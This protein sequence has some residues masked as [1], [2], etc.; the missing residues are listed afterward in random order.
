MQRAVIKNHKNLDLVINYKLAELNSKGL[1]FVQHGLTG[2]KEQS[3]IKA[4]ADS[5]IDNN[6]SVVVFDATNSV[7]ESGISEE[8]VSFASHY[9]DLE[10][11]IAWSGLQN[12]FTTPFILVGHSLGG[13][14]VIYYT[15]NHLKDIR[16]LVPVSSAFDRNQ[17]YELRK[18]EIGGNFN[19][20]KKNGFYEKTSAVTGRTVK[21][22]FSFLADSREVNTY[23]LKDNIKVKTIFIHGDCDT[24]I[25]LE[26]AK[27]FYDV[28]NCEK[29]F[30]IIKN[31]PHTMKSDENL[32]DLQN[33][34][35][36]IIE[37]DI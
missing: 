32:Q 12:W 9:N 7:G 20:W 10:D 3:H 21:V 6:Y 14:S 23:D 18:K 27:M 33:Y 5:F 19:E 11:V 22:P 36:N 37:E 16:L 29:E 34:L 25:P 30:K 4:I 8:G 24:V 35:L 17:V 13:M 31:C 26:H 1:V 2:C 15:Q 28:L